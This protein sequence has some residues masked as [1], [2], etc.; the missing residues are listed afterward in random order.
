[1]NVRPQW[2]RGQSTQSGR[3]AV[4]L[5]LDLSGAAG[6]CAGVRFTSWP[7]SFYAC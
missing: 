4:M 1:M 3:L 2:Q 5:A 6:W 7:A